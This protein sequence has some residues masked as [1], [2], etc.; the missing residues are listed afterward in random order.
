MPSVGQCPG[1]LTGYSKPL[2]AHAAS[3]ERDPHPGNQVA[4]TPALCLGRHANR[5]VQGAKIPIAAS[6]DNFEKEPIFET[7]GVGVSEGAVVIALI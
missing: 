4:A 2:L 3:Q 7:V 1:L 5:G 6:L